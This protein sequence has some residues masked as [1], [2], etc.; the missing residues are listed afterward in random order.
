MFEI[1]IL[2]NISPFVFFH[3]LSQLYYDSFASE[4]ILSLLRTDDQQVKAKYQVS[5]VC[6]MILKNKRRVCLE[7]YLI[8]QSSQEPWKLRIREFSENCQNFL[9]FL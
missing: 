4:T 5:R 1:S 2:I 3:S 6:H 9:Q 7:S 8:I